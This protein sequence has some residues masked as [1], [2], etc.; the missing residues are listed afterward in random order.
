M[1]KMLTPILLIAI[2]L[3]SSLFS[4]GTNELNNAETTETIKSLSLEEAIEEGIKNSV[5][6]EISDLEIDVK[7]MELKQARQTEREYDELS[8]FLDTINQAH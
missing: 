3:T 5:Q 4:Y 7:K 6:L 8:T 1:K 2:L